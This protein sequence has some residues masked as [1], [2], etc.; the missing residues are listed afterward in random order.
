MASDLASV[1]RRNR[2]RIDAYNAAHGHDHKPGE[3]FLNALP[4][5]TFD[6]TFA[7]DWNEEQDR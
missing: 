7:Q 3:L 5:D 2:D 4:E 6:D 1:Q